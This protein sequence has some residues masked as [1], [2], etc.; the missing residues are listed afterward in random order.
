MPDI[1]G[2]RT[3]LFGQGL[4]MRLREQWGA[5]YGDY[6]QDKTVE[7]PARWFILHIAVVNPTSMDAT[8]RTIEKIGIS[9]FPNTGMSY[10]A[11]VWPDGTLLEGQPLTRRG[12][13]TVNDKKT[14]GFPMPPATLNPAGRALVLPQ[15]IQHPCTDAQIDSGARWAAAQIRA[16]LARP[17][18]TWYGHR[19]FASKDCPGANGYN[20]LAELNQLTRE[21]TQTGLGDDMGAYDQDRAAILGTL[22]YLKGMTAWGWHQD[23]RDPPGF[24]HP[25]FNQAGEMARI[26][27]S[28]RDGV[29]ELRS[30]VD[31]LTAKVDEL[32]KK[33]DA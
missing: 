16:G 24:E 26:L 7:S 32:A 12:A 21:Y 33:S 22:G 25:A 13:H 23:D 15:N 2:E 31:G 19:D 10:N 4:T 1:A 14:A 30:Q 11:S 5:V 17:D 27:R 29:A 8:Q 28:L 20:R 18:A 9:R 6:G 3:A